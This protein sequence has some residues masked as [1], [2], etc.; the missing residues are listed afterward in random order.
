MKRILFFVLLISLTLEQTL[1]KR[2]VRSKHGQDCI[3]D[4]ACEEVLFCKINRCFT[5]YE[6][7]N[8]KA[9]GLLDKNL[10]S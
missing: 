3:S 6:S 8:L 4:S 9:L 10:C 5:K 2:I 1:L 7:Y